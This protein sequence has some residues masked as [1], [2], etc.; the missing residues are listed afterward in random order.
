MIVVT[1]ATGTFGHQVGQTLIQQGIPFRAGAQTTQAIR[2]KLGDQPEAVAFDW[3]NPETFRALLTGAS[4]VYVISPPFNY[5]FHTAVAS[6]V[7]EA[8]RQG[9]QHLVLT[10]G[11]F[12]EARPDNLFRRSEEIIQQAGIDYTILRPSFLMQNFINYDLQS[13]KNGVLYFPSGTGKAA[14]VD[15]Q[16]VATAS[17]QVLTNPESHVGKVYNLTGTEALSHAQMAQ[18]FTTVLGRTFQHIDPSV[19]EFQQTLKGYGVPDFVYEF[20]A[21]LYTTVKEGQWTKV[22]QDIQTITGQ[23]PRSFA[24]FVDGN[25]AVFS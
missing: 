3:Q 4:V 21:M 23:S 9:V 6:F 7:E 17:T 25:R 5:T 13:V 2:E 15:V 22:T 10:T 11:V 24:A 12:A 1:G 20:M 16:D 14:Y 19:E 18:I 8:K